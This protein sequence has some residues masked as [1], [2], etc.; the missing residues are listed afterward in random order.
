MLQNNKLKELENLK[1]LKKIYELSKKQGYEG[2]YEDFEKEC[3]DIV[4]NTHREISEKYL[5]KVSGGKLSKKFSKSTATVLSALTLSSVN[6]PSSSAVSTYNILRNNSIVDLLKKEPGK[7]LASATAFATSSLNNVVTGKKDHCANKNTGGIF[8]FDSLNDV[9]SKLTNKDIVGKN[10]D[11]CLDNLSSLISRLKYLYENKDLTPNGV[12]GC[13][14]KYSFFVVN[15]FE[16]QPNHEALERV[17]L[18]FN[19]EASKAGEDTELGKTFDVFKKLI[20]KSATIPAEVKDFLYNIKTKKD[21]NLS[22][23]ENFIEQSGGV[24]QSGTI[25]ELQ[26]RKKSQSSQE[27]GQSQQPQQPQR[28]DE[29]KKSEEP[30]KQPFGNSNLQDENE[31]LEGYIE[32]KVNNDGKPV[33]KE[34]Y[35]EIDKWFKSVQ[36]R[37]ERDYSRDTYK[38]VGNRFYVKQFLKDFYYGDKPEYFSALKGKQLVDI[39]SIFCTY[40]RNFRLIS[41][42][43]TI[44]F[45]IVTPVVHSSNETRE[46]L[47]REAAIKRLITYKENINPDFQVIC[48]AMVDV[49]LEKYIGSA[50]KLDEILRGHSGENINREDYKSFKISDDG[51]ISASKEH[52]DVVDNWFKKVQDDLIQNGH[53]EMKDAY[54]RIG[55]VFYFKKDIGNHISYFENL[56][57]NS[58]MEYVNFYF[59]RQEKV[60]EHDYSYFSY[61]EEKKRPRKNN[62]FKASIFAP[63]DKSFLILILKD[64]KSEECK[65]LT[66]DAAKKW[67]KD[68][69][70]RIYKVSN[71]YKIRNLINDYTEEKETQNFGSFYEKALF[72]AE[73]EPSS[74]EINDIEDW[75]KK[76][77]YD[78]VYNRKMSHFKGGCKR[79]GKEFY[80]KKDINDYNYFEQLHKL[81]KMKSV[82]AL[83]NAPGN[84][85]CS[86]SVLI[87]DDYSF[88]VMVKNEKTGKKYTIIPK[89]KSLQTLK[90]FCG[91][92]TEESKK[93]WS[94]ITEFLINNYS[95][96]ESEVPEGY[97]ELKFDNNGNE[98]SQNMYNKL[99]D[100]F[101][102]TQDSIAM[103]GDMRYSGVIDA[104]KHVGNK[105]YIKKEIQDSTA[106]ARKLGYFTILNYEEKIRVTVMPNCHDDQ[107]NPCNIVYYVPTNGPFLFLKIIKG[108]NLEYRVVPR[109]SA[110]DC[111]MKYINSITPNFFQDHD[112]Y[113]EQFMNLIRFYSDENLTSKINKDYIELSVYDG[114]GEASKEICDKIEEWFNFVENKESPKLRGDSERVGNKFYV[115]KYPKEKEYSRTKNYFDKISNFCV[116][117]YDFRI[118]ST[119]SDKGS[120]T[121]EI[122]VP[123]DKSFIIVSIEDKKYKILTRSA[124]QKHMDTLRGMI[125]YESEFNVFVEY[126]NN[127]PKPVQK[128]KI[129]LVDITDYSKLLIDNNKKV[130]EETY[131]DLDKWFKSVQDNLM[132]NN[133]S[134]KDT[135]IRDNNKFYVKRN[136]EGN[137]YFDELANKGIMEKIYMSFNDT[138]GASVKRTFYIPTNGKSFLIS[139][140]TG[141]YELITKEEAKRYIKMVYDMASEESKICYQYDFDD[142]FRYYGVNN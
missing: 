66:R 83:V 50:Y 137:R 3:K 82:D 123:N 10:V 42:K 128:K 85:I 54:K 59:F 84:R 38:R 62:N 68:S 5:E 81:G 28:S 114:D 112:Y 27:S 134:L 101:Q 139:A 65:I 103:S 12:R 71:G 119:N 48:N 76:A 125:K 89:G 43:N 51:G 34:T 131:N 96:D 121:L 80:F 57:L 40:K 120:D 79:I 4:L 44:S 23:F 95:K 124:V 78:L 91:S 6:I 41:P 111:I 29:S 53:T 36:S 30:P 37:L 92:M 60:N 141:E 49:L 52:C 109:E 117:R 39:R 35:D 26:E 107:G 8:G 46:I 1:S 19:S 142:L 113:V 98:I 69:T 104:V 110:K 55:D 18:S 63:E 127:I 116:M 31:N 70:D 74:K 75:F 136:I 97:F 32:L 20:I 135:Y 138:K 17:A 130:S 24:S 11:E 94:K 102:A 77:E 58:K 140:Q 67:L 14:S 21:T 90:D 61:W 56:C 132:E 25:G 9:S 108:D 122:I 13:L 15:K 86:A 2:T 105:F 129:E 88:L 7:T 100:W 16:K 47:T 72:S 106:I 133:S 118:R 126:Y 115:K 73:C 93:S 99:I 64:T 33:S 45:L 22:N 87:P